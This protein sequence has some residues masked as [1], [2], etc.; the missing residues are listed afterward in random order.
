MKASSLAATLAAV[1][2]LAG[3]A[4]EASSVYDFQ[5]RTLRGAP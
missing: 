5:W 4:A 3:P 2:A 1:A